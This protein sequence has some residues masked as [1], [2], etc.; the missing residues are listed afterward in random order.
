MPLFPSCYR[1]SQRPIWKILPKSTC[2][3]EAG[4]RCQVLFESILHWRLQVQCLRRKS[5]SCGCRLAEP[6]KSINTFTR[7]GVVFLMNTES[8]TTPSDHQSHTQELSASLYVIF[9]SLLQSSLIRNLRLSESLKK[10]QLW[11]GIISI[12]LL[13]GR[14]VSG[15]SVAE[16]FVQLKLG[17]QRYKSKVS[18]VNSLRRTMSL[19]WKQWEKNVC[20]PPLNFAR[21]KFIF[22]SPVWIRSTPENKINVQML[23]VN[24]GIWLLS[25]IHFNIITGARESLLNNR[26]ECMAYFHFENE[27]LCFRD[28]AKK[29]YY[30]QK[31][32]KNKI[33]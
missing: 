14:N 31:S 10:N 16:M 2:G 9:I 6:V 7:Q 8:W 3:W 17:D 5:L 15:G 27:Q 33:L 4:A 1:S 19:R 21:T 23:S 11:N 32:Y 24:M 28:C 20:F 22:K 30:F 29:D 26:F 25:V 12:T 18:S 13:E